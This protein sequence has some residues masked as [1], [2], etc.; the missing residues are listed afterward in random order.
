MNIP[1]RQYTRDVRNFAAL[2][3]L[4]T[5]AI[6]YYLLIPLM[7]LYVYI[8]LDF[9]HQQLVIFLYCATFT[10][11]LSAVTTI[12]N[13]HYVV[14]P[15]VKYFRKL[16]SGESFSREE[17]DYA[18]ARFRKLPF[19]HSLGA[20]FRWTIG[21]T[22]VNLLTAHFAE[23]NRVQAVNMWLLLFVNGPMCVVLF[24]LQSELYLQK[25]Y[26]QGVF[27]TWV[28][29]KR[30]F[31]IKII[32]KLLPTSIIIMLVPFLSILAYLLHIS[33]KLDIDKSGIYFRISCITLIG[34]ILAVYV[35]IILAK[36]INIKVS[37]VNSILKEL[38]KGNLAVQS[39]K[40]IV[41]DELSNINKSVYKMKENLKRLVRAIADNSRVLEENG[42]GLEKTSS[43]MADAARSL[44][45]ITEEASSAYE[46]MSSAFDMNVERIKE[47]QNEFSHMQSVVL[48]IAADTSQLKQRTSEIMKSVKITLDK[49]D[50]GRE[51]MSRTVETMKDISKFVDN[52]DTM[53]NMITDIA[54]KINLLALNASIEAARAGDHGKGFAVVAD[55]VNK[56]ADQTSLLAGDIKKNISEQSRRI[57]RELDNIMDTAA[58]LDVIRGSISETS[59]VIGNT[60]E[61]TERL[62]EKN[63]R[64]ESDIEKF[65]NISKDIHDSS[66]EQQVTIDEL[67]K[68]LNSVNNYAQLTAENSDRISVLS[69][70]LNG[71]SHELAKEIGQIKV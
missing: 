60:F 14:K 68:A 28:E 8:N 26:M 19:Y 4:K 22:V 34:F 37:N 9:D 65:S 39:T 50:E 25:I 11:S 56:L 32:Q 17:Y 59:G 41:V 35:S 36:S 27:P 70:D 47:Q 33:S 13:N 1:E 48:D 58:V 2:F 64:I 57:S 54:D 46:E 23:I 16:S 10:A 3:F 44:S 49:T 20:M 45:A 42:G 31:S 7:I 67:T 6:S 69:E 53:V 52:I 62:S 51:S 43:E 66:M 18:F 12:V 15:V 63:R 61:F 21:M 5:D 55:E 40:L 24:F 38:T 30:V 29:L 71:R